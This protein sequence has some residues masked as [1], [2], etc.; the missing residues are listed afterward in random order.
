LT[1]ILGD[2]NGIIPLVRVG[3]AIGIFF[4]QDNKEKKR[5]E[6]ELR[7]RIHGFTNTLLVNISEITDA[8]TGE[9]YKLVQKT[10]YNAK[11]EDNNEK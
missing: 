11:S 3:A 6:E 5:K 1:D 4:Y 7:D 10:Y 9:K 2:H 8:L